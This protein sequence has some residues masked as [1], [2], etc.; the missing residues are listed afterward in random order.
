M[1]QIIRQLFLFAAVAGF[2]ACSDE[3]TADMSIEGIKGDFAYI[4]GGT[5]AMYQATTCEV[6]HTPDL[7]DGT[8][9]MNLT[10]A[11]TRAQSHDTSIEIGVDAA[12]ISDGYEAVPDGL[13]QFENP[14]TIPAGEKSRTISVSIAQENL[15][16]LTQ[17]QYMAPFSILAVNGVQISSNSNTAILIISTETIDPA[18]N[19]IN[20]AGATHTFSVKNYT[21]E[22]VGDSISA[23]IDIEGSEPAYKGFAIEL[24][25]DNSL[26]AD[27]NSEHGTSYVALPSSVTLSIS[28]PFMETNATQV[29]AQV[30]MADDE[31]AKLTDDNGY[32]VPIVVKDASPATIA[33]DCGVTYLVIDVVNFDTSSDFFYA[34]YLGDYRMSTWYQFQQPI[35]L[36]NGYTYVFH[37]FID[38]VTRVSRIGDFADINENW[39]NMLRFG[40]KGNND[41][42]LE[43]NVGPNGCRQ[44]LYTKALEPQT[45]YQIALIYTKDAFNLYV[46][47]ELQDSYTLTDQDKAKLATL[48]KPAFQA[49]EFN[50]SWGENYREGNE[51]HGRLWHMGV[52][53]R[54]IDSS[55]LL[56]YCYH[57]FNSMLLTLPYF[58]LQA[59]WG[60][61]EGTGAVTVEGT[62]R[63]ESIDFT[64]TIRCDDE[65]TMVPADVSS[66]IQWVS[67]QYNHFD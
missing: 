16:Q 51:F 14:V 42:R 63:Y 64:K 44:L 45:W 37:I 56:D 57:D 39:I 53:D 4:V 47:G 1:K 2:V 38:E 24:G 35:D 31:R 65:S 26:I 22:T 62:G 58:G 11:L 61:D 9:E 29:S 59:Y 30:S 27:Y 33:P 54:A 3:E 48:V 34:L 32:L 21:N 15:S 55:W 7:E 46:E 20:V 8:V 41:T 10:V 40:Q 52:F 36:S 28:E 67:D 66:Y 23:T 18:D 49:I 17:P 19:L 12:K 25:V 50:S 60:F 43:W 5:E 13:L 6:F